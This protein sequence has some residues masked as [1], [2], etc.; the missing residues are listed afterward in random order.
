MADPAYIVDGVLTDG[1]AWVALASTTLS[2]DTALI[3]FTSP[4]D[5]SSKDWSQFMD[6]V[7]VWY[8]RGPGSGTQL[9]YMTMTLNNDT[10]AGAYP[11]QFQRGNNNGVST[12]SDHAPGPAYQLLA[13]IPENGHAA[14]IFAGGVC[15]IFDIN[16]GKYKSMMAMTA[17]DVNS[18]GTGESRI[19]FTMW[20]NTAAV[21]EIDIKQL[22][23][24]NLETG[25]RWDLF[26]V[27]PRMVS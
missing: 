17:A 26:G 4:A 22:F 5:G 27:L 14:G 6:L 23:G 12:S 2:S 16:S 15:H 19:D 7:I 11:N 8:A 25:S 24:S 18:G 3:T 10:S 21:S 1:E 13:M 9:T 20:R